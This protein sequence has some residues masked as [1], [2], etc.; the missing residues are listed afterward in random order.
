[1]Q[2]DKDF[3]IEAVRL[4]DDIGL[5]NA[6]NQLGVNYYTLADWRSKLKHQGASAFVGSGNK[7]L[8]QSDAERRIKELEAELRETK[9]ANEIL[10]EALGF[11]A[12]S[13]KK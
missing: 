9:R 1:M 12:T 13:R 11:F 10:K 4:A 6:A 8:P 3:K 7:Q 5:K 2:Y